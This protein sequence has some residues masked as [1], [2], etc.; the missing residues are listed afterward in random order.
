MQR[1]IER[2]RG[3]D[4]P[5]WRGASEQPCSGSIGKV[6]EMIQYFL[7]MVFWSLIVA[8]AGRSVWLAR[9]GKIASP[10]SWGLTI[11]FVTL[12]LLVVVLAIDM[13]Y[14]APLS[15]MQD[16]VPA[17]QTLE[18]E[19]RA[20]VLP[21]A[22]FK[23]RIKAELD[24]E[25]VAFSLGKLWPRLAIEEEEE[26]NIAEHL[27][28]SAH[29]PFM[30]VFLIPFVSFLGVPGTFLAMALISI[31]FQCIA[32]V[33]I[34]RGLGLNLAPTEKILVFFCCLAWYPMDWVLRGGQPNVLL[35]GL[36]VIGWYSIRQNHPRWA[37]I[38]VGIAT[39]MKIFPGL[40]L[41][42]FLLRHRR[43]FWSGTLTIL[44]LH[45]LTVATMGIR[46]HKDYVRTIGRVY[47]AAGGSVL[48]YSLSGVLHRVSEVFGIQHLTTM[49]TLIVTSLIVVGVMCWVVLGERAGYSRIDRY[50]LEYSLFV[51]AMPLLS[52]IC[53][54]HYFVI[55]LLPLAVL[56]NLVIRQ[57]YGVWAVTGWVALVVALAVPDPF[58][59]HLLPLIHGVNW[60]LSCLFPIL[61]SIALI[62]LLV[63]I[64]FLT[65]TSCLLTSTP[66][67]EDQKADHME[68]H[69]ALGDTA[70][71]F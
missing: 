15:I 61:P 53:W 30:V 9:S 18:G 48:N 31:G 64:G 2:F 59:Q 25:H 23:A 45:L 3:T 63:W 55:L 42:F 69:T 24:E 35:M 57:N 14:I 51:A 20:G 8:I 70:D 68:S 29:P 32:L 34:Q 47:N 28:D 36:I 38:A 58:M 33:L 41:L 71:R 10:P 17:Q 39:S 67:L 40:L 5:Q 21:R 1:D 43:A 66:M 13:G 56:M 12:S 62:G 16:I 19:T 22:D 6:A 60:R 52:P 44:V 26:H 27:D 50:D 7:A 54:F 37:G 65:R 4:W 11:L 49:P 46:W